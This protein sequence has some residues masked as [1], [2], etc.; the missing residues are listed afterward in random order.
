MST[1]NISLH[2]WPATVSFSTR[3]KDIHGTV[4]KIISSAITEQKAVSGD[5]IKTRSRHRG[6]VTQKRPESPIGSIETALSAQREKCRTLERKLAES[7]ILLKRTMESR[8]K[9]RLLVEDIEAVIF[10][11]DAKGVITYINPRIEQFTGYPPSKFIGQHFLDV[12]YRPD[13]EKVETFYKRVTAGHI[14]SNEYRLRHRIRGYMWARTLS[15]PVFEKGVYKGLRGVGIDISRLKSAEA[16]A[17]R[18]EKK[19]QSLLESIEE[20]YFEVNLNG[21]IVFVSP[22]MCRITGLPQE[23]LVGKKYRS[24][25]SRKMARRLKRIFLGIYRSG[26]HAVRSD[27]I[28]T[29]PGR[30]MIVEVSASLITGDKGEPLGYRGLIRD[31]TDR[32]RYERNQKRLE[33]QLEEAQRLEAVGTLAGGI[34]HNFN[35]ILMAMQ[36]NISLLLL[37]SDPE[38]AMVEKLQNL[39]QC[40]HDGAGLTRQLLDF[41]RS[42][43]SSVE[44][45]NL[46]DLI[47]K[48]S[49]MFGRAKREITMDTSGLKSIWNAEVDSNQIQQVLLNL[50]VNAWQAM[51]KGGRLSVRSCNVILNEQFVEAHGL[52]P[53]RY[54]KIS[55]T[56]TGEGMDDSVQQKIFHPFFTTK[57]NHRGT[58]LGLTSA[59]GIIKSHG[60][61]ILVNSR[62]GRGT[63]FCIYLPASSKPLSPAPPTPEK[64]IRGSGTILVVD[65][66]PFILDITCEGLKE[67]GYSVFSARNGRAAVD[68]YKSHGS[69]V[70]L[71]ILDLIMPEMDGDETFHRL[72]AINPDVRVLL[73]SGYDYNHR[74]EAL[75]QKGC[76]GFIQKPFNMNQLSQ[77]VSRLLTT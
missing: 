42:R 4:E 25:V 34:A 36:G 53:G 64:P 50:Y 19:Y 59:Y 62:K 35:N 13:R 22:T 23:A 21:R 72:Q 46:N 11:I 33:R 24:F 15:R 1:Y 71:V 48:T 70:D 74:V 67:I 66:E 69:Q 6:P 57:E 55:V 61:M 18:T 76:R 47:I 65:D 9:F 32:R 14:G 8:E 29:T 45:E 31:I 54:V 38:D 58:G 37:K 73:T 52:P 12:V 27:L 63:T 43:K 26:R 49:R 5:A 40:I 30:A 2:R 10:A 68:I 39:E 7:L 44:P 3:A 77:K 28:F 41:A 16:A 56:D 60:G 75:R 20:G 51:P 17:Q